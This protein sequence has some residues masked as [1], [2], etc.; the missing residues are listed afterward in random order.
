MAQRILG[1][2]FLA[3]AFTSAVL[4][5][6]APEQPKGEVNFID[7]YVDIESMGVPPDRLPVGS[8]AAYA[9]AHRAAYVLAGRNLA[10]ILSGLYIQS[11]TSFTDAGAHEFSDKVKAELLRTR[12]PGGKVIEETSMEE[13][14]RNNR[15]LMTVRYPL[16]TALPELMRSVAPHLKE[17]EKTLPVAPPPSEPVKESAGYDGLIV[18]VPEGFQPSI[19][20]KIFNSKGQLVYGANSVSMDVLVSQGVAQFT[21]QSSKARA[22]LEAHGAKNILT[23]SA[24]LHAGNKDV[25]LDDMEANKILGANAQ[26]DFLAKGRVVLVV[27]G[28]T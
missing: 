13:F 15:V 3:V 20:P 26:T 1:T 21:N 11:S 6:T 22:G 7:R 18:T 12:I 5:Q 17:V 16:N 28:G 23:V 27:G 10:E 9:D 4:A 2:V 8:P 24:S 14:K 25:D 19:A